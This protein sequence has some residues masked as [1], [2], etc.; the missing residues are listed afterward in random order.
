MTTVRVHGMTCQGC[1]SVVETAV[2]FLDD[3]ESVSAD[4]YENVVEVTGD[5]TAE[6]IGQKVELAGYDA[7]GE[8]DDDGSSEEAE[9]TDEEPVEDPD[10]DDELEE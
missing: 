5:V 9:V 10:L 7:L 2:G 4:R 6:E 3:V 1:E 8:A